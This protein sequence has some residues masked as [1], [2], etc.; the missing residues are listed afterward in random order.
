M[1]S[2]VTL[3]M[4]QAKTKNA[5]DIL[6]TSFILKKTRFVSREE[7]PQPLKGGRAPEDVEPVKNFFTL[8]WYPSLSLLVKFR[9]ARDQSPTEMAMSTAA[10]KSQSLNLRR[11]N[12]RKRAKKA[13]K[14]RRPPRRSPKSHLRTSLKR[15]T[16]SWTASS[17]THA[18]AES[19]DSIHTL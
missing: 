7:D 9:V 6:E 4:L 16:C 11:P 3:Q 5:V 14:R 1:T 13:K 19:A 8:F 12:R 18:A 10:R 15:R 2:W 17:S